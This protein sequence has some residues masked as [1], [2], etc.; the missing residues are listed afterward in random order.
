[1]ASAARP[2]SSGEEQATVRSM[3]EAG[4]DSLDFLSAN[5]QADRAIRLLRK[6][7]ISLRQFT[8]RAWKIV[9]PAVAFVPNWHI[10]AISEHLE[11]CSAGEIQ[12]LVINIP[13]RFMKSLNVSVM[14]PCWE[15][16]Y[17]PWLRSLFSSY[18]EALSK[19]DSLK[20]RYIIQSN[21]YQRRWGHVYQLRKD[22]NE[23]LRFDN[24]ETGFRVA[25][26][27]DGM[28][29]GEGGDRIVVDDP[30]NVRE[31]QSEKA[32]EAVREWWDQAMSTRGNNPATTVRVITMQRV[33]E[34]DLTGHVLAKERGYVHL[35]IPMEY[36]GKKTVTTIGWSDPRTKVGELEL[37][38]VDLG[39]YG[40]AA[41]FQQEPAPR[42]GAI[43]QEEWFR[44]YTTTDRPIPGVHTMP[45][46]M[47]EYI[48]SW[49]MAF[50]GDKDTALELGSDFVVGDVWS[51]NGAQIY[52]RDQV[53]GQW[54]LPETIRQ[55]TA[56]SEKWP[57][58]NAKYIEDKAN[59]P[60]VVS[61]LRAKISGLILLDPKEL[62]G[63]KVARARAAAPVAEAMQI[64]IPHPDLA[65]SFDVG[66][67]LIEITKFPRATRDD[68]TD[69]AVQAWLVLQQHIKAS[70]F[71]KPPGDDK[72]KSPA[73]AAAQQRF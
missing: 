23:K 35:K 21:W 53:R 13:P 16:S 45:P 1:M 30:H 58:A 12:R 59:G 14:W 2:Q 29:T 42:K 64:F 70:T 5:A 3:A 34:A 69:A 39:S 52:L 48:Q 65:P 9:E 18:A 63:D 6:P 41:Q 71:R 43:F 33:N 11:A 46:V 27:V 20:C 62:G 4:L 19:R 22:Q 54:E 50:K 60:A 55:V 8:A 73:A 37:L 17:A 36:D 40:T 47:S 24:T 31:G 38:K 25:T 7:D 61:S 72:Q 68:R 32:L 67:W 10:D 57:D 28:G 26:S 66:A 49:D 44:Y 51:R 56:L 15:W